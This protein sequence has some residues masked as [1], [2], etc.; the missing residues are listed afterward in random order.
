MSY[1]VATLAF[2]AHANYGT[3]SVDFDN[4]VTLCYYCTIVL[5]PKKGFV[6]HFVLVKLT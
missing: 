2:Q 3:W 1:D 4:Y 5:L 6:K